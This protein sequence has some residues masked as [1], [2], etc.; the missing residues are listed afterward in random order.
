MPNYS[1]MEN[2]V[3]QVKIAPTAISIAD[4]LEFLYN[5]E[6]ALR[7]LHNKQ[8]ADLKEGKLAEASWLQW[9][10]QY[11]EPRSERIAGDIGY[12]K[13]QLKK[14]NKYQIDLDTAF[15]LL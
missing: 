5:A 15:V 6:E 7:L 3:E 14:S 13:Y 9:K 10:E 1:W 4:K 2:Y 8:G 11:F 12:Y